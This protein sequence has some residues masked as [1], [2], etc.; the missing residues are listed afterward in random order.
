[1]A[2]KEKRPDVEHLIKSLKGRVYR[3]GVLRDRA[4]NQVLA[5]K[6]QADANKLEAEIAKL[7]KGKDKSRLDNIADRATR[8]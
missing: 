1:M 8:K 7:S 5:D 6:F 2:T 4:T 3:Y